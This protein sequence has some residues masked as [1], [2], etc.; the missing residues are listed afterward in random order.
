MARIS[1]HCNHCKSSHSCR[2]F[3]LPIIPII[4]FSVVDP[5]NLA[6][7]IARKPLLSPAVIFNQGEDPSDTASP[8]KMCQGLIRC[9]EAALVSVLCFS[10]VCCRQWKHTL[11]W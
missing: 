4:I 3:D 11:C 7:Q 6:A 5:E 1:L 10:E 2:K 9:T 8:Q